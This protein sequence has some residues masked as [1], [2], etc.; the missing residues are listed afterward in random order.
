MTTAGDA[1]ARRRA[2]ALR[3]QI[4]QANDAYYNNDAPV[5]SD[6]DYDRFF[7]ELQALEAAHPALRTPDSPT[8][9]VGAE[10]AS[11]LTKHQHLRPML[12]LANAFDTEELRAWHDRNLRLVPDAAKSGFVMEVKI[13][14]AAVNLTYRDGLL[15]T[16]A[17][18]GNG[19]IGEDITANLRTISDVPLSLRGTDVP[20]LIEVRGE[21]YFPYATFT[22]LNEQR[23]AAGEPLY[24]NPRNSA[25]GSLRQL[26][27]EITRRRRLR[28]FAFHIEVLE[29]R[30]PVETQWELLDRL[31]AW[32][33]Q[34]EAHRHRA[35]DLEAV[36]AQVP[37]FE[38][39]LPTLPFQSDGVVVKVNQMTLHRRLGNVGDRE[40]RWSI[41]RK[42]APET[43]VTRLLDIR[44]NVGR[45]GALNPYAVLEPVE[46][47]GVTVSTATLHNDQLIA[48]KDI[49]IG[50][51]VEV[52]RAGEVIPQ[53]IGPVRERRDGRERRFMPPKR[54]PDCGTPVEQPPDEVMRY[55]PNV[56]CPGRVFEG[57]VHFA[58]R[59]AMDIRG[60]GYERVRQLLDAGLIRDVADLFQLQVEPL[61]TLE[62]FA[63]QSATQ[64]VKAIEDARSRPLSTLLFALGVRHVGTTAAQLLARRFR[65]MDGLAQASEEE[66]LE[67][68]G[69]GPTIADAVRSFFGQARNRKLIDRL[70]AAGV[71]MTE[72]ETTAP[73]G[74]LAGERL[75]ITGVLPTLSRAEAT[76]LIEEAGGRVVGG[77]SANTSAVVAGDK[78]GSK[79]D[80]A[81]T[82][83]VPVIDEAELLRRVGH[84]L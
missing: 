48:D 37:H 68:P 41:A 47:S 21:V 5:M 45:T 58:S 52:M 69:I 11:A 66:I 6:A 28:M 50:D 82:L 3:K 46:V 56:A 74:P 55:C 39:L 62:R 42:F 10:P 19:R 49:R 24:A 54:C 64:L 72:P 81:R 51:W 33:F 59:G 22:R 53:V 7:R 63:E 14:G 75:V 13:D 78:P 38:T 36:I 31:A 57:I 2:E 44:V 67:I 8:L 77:V 71:T 17:T 30:M 25:A 12:S 34:V 76:A 9:R 35:R 79:F 15:V 43:A 84:R 18:R 23:E 60:L 73:Y 80:K 70:R 4:D 27:S 16:G 61:M 29:G 20:P 83:G 65:T 26:D 40:P 1:E 32:G